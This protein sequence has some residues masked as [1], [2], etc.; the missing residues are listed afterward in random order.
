MSVLRMSVQSST[1]KVQSR[2][3]VETLN[4]EHSTL[5]R[6]SYVIESSTIVPQNFALARL[7]DAIKLQKCLDGMRIGGVVVRPIGGNDRVLITHGLNGVP[8]DRLIRING[9]IA[10]TSKIFAGGHF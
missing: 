5:N 9:D 6:V 10:V 8:Q 1:F 4:P 2:K 7:A 3:R